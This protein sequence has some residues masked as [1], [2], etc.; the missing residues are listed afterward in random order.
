MDCPLAQF[1]DADTKPVRLLLQKRA[2]PGS[3]HA[4]HRKINNDPIIEQDQFRVLSTDINHRLYI[5]D[6]VKRCH[7]VSCD[8]ILHQVSPY[9][10]TGQL[11][12]ASGG[13]H[14][15]YMGVTRQQ[16]LYLP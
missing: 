2:R 11:P 7:C 1:I 16:S 6:K 14:T 4:V 10:S 8:L 15:P 13:A 3:A 5:W 12:A 9:N